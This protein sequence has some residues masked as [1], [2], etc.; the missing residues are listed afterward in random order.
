MDF[1][2]IHNMIDEFVEDIDNANTGEIVRL[3][4]DVF[5]VGSMLFRTSHHLPWILKVFFGNLLD[6]LLHPT[7]L[8]SDPQSLQ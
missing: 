4:R 5:L 2:R 8:Y 6:T 7:G 3:F 1:N